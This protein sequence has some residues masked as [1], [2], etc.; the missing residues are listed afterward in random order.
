MYLLLKVHV[1]NLRLNSKSNGQWSDISLINFII[2]LY[3]RGSLALLLHT[4]SML[5]I[6]VAHCWKY[7]CY[8]IQSIRISNVK[9]SESLSHNCTVHKAFLVLGSPK[10]RLVQMR[11]NI[12]QLPFYSSR[13]LHNHSNI[14]LYIH[15][16]LNLYESNF[17]YIYILI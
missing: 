15:A 10:M 5:F 14:I 13:C 9:W 11:Q 7:T 1:H 16:Y 2:S 6:Y 4:C 8:F 17:L 3:K 12:T